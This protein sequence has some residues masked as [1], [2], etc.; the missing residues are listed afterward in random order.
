MNLQ[1]ERLSHLC[2]ELRLSGLAVEYPAAAQKAAESE[3][4]FIDFLE[5]VLRGELDTRRT[6]AR[7]MLS[8]VAGFPAIKTLDQFEFEF[9]FEFAVGA[10]RQQIQQLA[11]LGFIERAEN[12]ILLGQFDPAS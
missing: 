1:Y 2:T 5:V 9:E 10:P 12:V 4:S 6:R 8:R 3:A 7:T 11:G